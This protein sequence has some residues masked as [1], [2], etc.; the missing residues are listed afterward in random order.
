MNKLSFLL[1]SCLLFGFCLTQSRA[2][3]QK[4]VDPAGEITVTE[5]VPGVQGMVKGKIGVLIEEHFDEA[6][7]AGF[8][9]FFPENG[10]QVE[11]ISYLWGHDKLTFTG[12][13]HRAQVIVSTDITKINLD[14]YDGIILIGGY[15]MDRLRYETHLDDDGRSTAP[16]V[17][18][19]R[20]VV[21]TDRIK[22]GTIC[23]SLWLFTAAPDLLKGKKV[24]S[25]LNIVSDVRNAGGVLQVHDHQPVDIYVDGNLISAK[26]PAVLNL[27]MTTFL[28]EL[29]RR[30]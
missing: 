29:N 27:F 21:Q 9:Q 17:R 18:F 11:F 19:L 6:E 4:C 15:A 12:N 28:N 14:E 7:L 13:D 24:T 2:I 23:H 10:Y 30:H 1:C 8:Q 16:A 5:N 3:A 25:A 26:H 20:Q 22:I